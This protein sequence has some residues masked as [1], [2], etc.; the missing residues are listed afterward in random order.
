MSPLSGRTLLGA[1]IAVL[2]VVAIGVALRQ[3]G[4]PAEARLRRL[5][6]RRVSDLDEIAGS[7]DRFWTASQRLPASL[8]EAARGGGASVPRDPETGEPYAYRAVDDRRYEI[9]A[10]FARSSNEVPA[11]HQPPFRAH[12]SGRQCFTI[13]PGR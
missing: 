1:F 6:E 2:A 5:D 7:L 8:E 12:A 4:S 13:A 9:C 11:M 10:T 3:V